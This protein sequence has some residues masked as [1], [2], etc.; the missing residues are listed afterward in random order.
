MSCSAAEPAQLPRTLPAGAL[1]VIEKLCA[2]VVID[3]VENV[4]NV[5]TVE[6]TQV[7]G[8]PGA[9]AHTWLSLKLACRFALD[10]PSGA[11]GSLPAPACCLHERNTFNDRI[12]EFVQSQHAPWGEQLLCRRQP[13]S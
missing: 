1:V 10:L 4:G 8:G 6:S 13:P 12:E 3:N 9:R 2:V 5:D 7:Q 11:R